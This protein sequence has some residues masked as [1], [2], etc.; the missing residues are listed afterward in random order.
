MI[1]AQGKIVKRILIQGKP[2]QVQ[3]NDGSVPEV[4]A[5]VHVTH[6]DSGGSSSSSA[7]QAGQ[8]Q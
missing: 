7:K 5:S 2:T 1:P 4:A 8:K 3:L 6:L